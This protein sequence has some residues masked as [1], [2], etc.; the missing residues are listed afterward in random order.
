M[1]HETSEKQA[2]SALE[3]LGQFRKAIDLQKV[4]SGKSLSLS[5]ALQNTIADYNKTVVR[6]YRVD[7]PKNKVILNLMRSPGEFVQ[8][9]SDHYDKFKHTMSGVLGLR[10]GFSAVGQ[11][12]GLGGRKICF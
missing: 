5:T 1:G 9:L 11:A 4:S 2:P 6:K 12:W 3:F 8:L 7:G 10:S